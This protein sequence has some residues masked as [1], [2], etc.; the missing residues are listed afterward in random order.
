MCF[1][2]VKS[3]RGLCN[4]ASPVSVCFQSSLITRLCVWCISG[5]QNQNLLIAW[6]MKRKWIICW[7]YN[8]LTHLFR[9]LTYTNTELKPTRERKQ[10]RINTF[11]LFIQHQSS[12]L[13]EL[14][15]ECCNLMTDKHLHFRWTVTCTNN[16][17]TLWDV[18][19]KHS[20]SKIMIT[21]SVIFQ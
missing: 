19:N 12:I 20:Y 21:D 6:E 1:I 4:T 10:V 7:I 15:A 13:Y 18:S 14:L 11:L 3:H 16:T 2:H 17:F 9:T 8:L 5:F